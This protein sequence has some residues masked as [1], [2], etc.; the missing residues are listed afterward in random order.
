MGLPSNIKSDSTPVSSIR[1]KVFSEIVRFI[2][3]LVLLNIIDIYFPRSGE[4]SL[5]L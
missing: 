3:V 5:F 4:N 2:T 1:I